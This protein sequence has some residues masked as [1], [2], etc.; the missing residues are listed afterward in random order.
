MALI[1]LISIV[2]KKFKL[3][4]PPKVSVSGFPS[5][6][7]NGI[8]MFA[9]MK[10]LK[11]GSPLVNINCTEKFQITNPQSLGLRFPEC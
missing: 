7:G 4:T 1:S 2:Q 11:N 10:K 3:L 5:V 6:D 8:S 9:I